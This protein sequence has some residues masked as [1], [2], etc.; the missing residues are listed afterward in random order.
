MYETT[1][2][3]PSLSPHNIKTNIFLLV[4]QEESKNLMKYSPRPHSSFS[5]NSDVRSYYSSY[6][7]S[8]AEQQPHSDAGTYYT[9]TPIQQQEGGT[10]NIITQGNELDTSENVFQTF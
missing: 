8:P 10:P 9:S 6:T 4:F 3:L 7:P 1:K 2:R 5:Q